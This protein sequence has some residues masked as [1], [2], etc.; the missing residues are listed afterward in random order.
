MQQYARI[1]A[2]YPETVLLFRMGDFYETFEDDAVTTSRVLGITLTKRGN[3]TAGEI[4]LA[5]FPYHALEAYLPKLLR[6]GFRV[7]IC[8]QLE[9]PKLAKGIVKRDVVEVVTPG[10]AFSE[11]VLDQKQNNYLAALALPHAVA[12]GGEIIGFTFV[13]ISTG[14]FFIGEFAFRELSDQMAS[15]RP[16]EVLVQ[17]RDF[18]SIQSMLRKSYAG[19]T[20]AP[21]LTKV[22]DWVFNYDY[23]YELLLSHFRTQTLKGFGCEQYQIGIVAAG[24]VMN[25]LQETQKSNLS[26]IRRLRPYESSDYIVLDQSTQRN[27]EITTQL[28]SGGGEG[29]LFS[30]LDR[31][32]TPMGGRLLK[33]WVSRPLKK[34]DPI[35]ERLDAVEELSEQSVKLEAIRR[36]LDTIGDLERLTGKICTGRANPREVVQLCSILEV[37]PSLK[38]ETN[39]LLSVLHKRI[40]GELNPLGDLVREIKKAVNDDPPIL[41]SD[42]GVIRRGYSAELDELRNLSS[43]GKSWIADLQMKERKRTGIGSLKV[44]YNRVFGYYIEITNTHKEKI[45]AD[46]IRKQTLTNAE[47]FITPDLKEYEEKI[48]HAEESIARLESELFN[49]LRETVAAE[50]AAIQTDSAAIAMLDVLSS[51][52]AIARKNKYVRPSV[53]DGDRIEI[54]SGRHPVIESL[55][56]PGERYVPN[57]TLLDLESHQILIITGPNMSGKSSFIRQVGLIVLLAQIGSY[58]PA[59]K[60]DIGIVD[61]IF[62]RVGASD[63]IASGESTFLVEMHEAANIVNTATERSLILL[64]EVGRGTSTFDG[65]SIAWAL[66]E[67][68]HGRLGAK[69][70]FATHYHELNE[71]AGLFPRI[72]NYRVDVREYGDKVIFLHKVVP[73]FADHS[74]GIQVA[75]LAGLPEEITDRAKLILKNLEKSGLSLRDVDERKSSQKEELR[76]SLRDGAEELQ[77]TLFEIKDDKLREQIKKLEPERMTPLEALHYL[78]KLKEDLGE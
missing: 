77:M 4:P 12:N 37:V 74:Y 13:D 29:T 40:D 39:G 76:K 50:A 62:T 57:D 3:G 53:T 68:I 5:G 9:D 71:L 75:R 20:V 16:S 18:E 64:D 14:E 61:K 35:R 10:V 17:K 48:L 27:L 1:K 52:A 31:T 72:Q 49:R 42:G 21:L 26:H 70:I 45:P 28:M 59:E 32:L 47:R 55:L 34:L 41:L 73:G 51:F 56:P 44:G 36:I 33:Q 60:A 19:R 25:Y 66:T 11:K 8:E 6:A 38:A 7:A 2:K 22:D 23:G 24:A 30:L 78:A 54:I 15:I 63:N 58:V 69:T 67:Y 43:S 46:Y 65:I